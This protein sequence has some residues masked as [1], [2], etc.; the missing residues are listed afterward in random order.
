M[1]IPRSDPRDASALALA[2]QVRGLAGKLKR[3]LRE[4]GSLGDLTPSQVAVLAHLERDGP[5]TVGSLART[6]GVRPQSMGATTAVLQAAG[7]IEGTPDPNDGRQTILALT[8]ACRERVAAS[9]AAREDWLCRTISAELSPDERDQ[10]AA[11]LA[12]LN[13]IL[14]G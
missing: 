14:A 7:L 11:G 3:R 5:R 8:A 13:R 12:L 6:E 4:H 9:R 2:E 1:S 10:L